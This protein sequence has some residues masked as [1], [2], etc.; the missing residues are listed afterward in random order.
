MQLFYCL[1]LLTLLLPCKEIALEWREKWQ[2]QE[3]GV[4]G[5]WIKYH[6]YTPI[7]CWCN[8]SII[9]DICVC[10]E[11]PFPIQKPPTPTVVRPPPPPPT[12][13]PLP[14][15]HAVVRRALQRLDAW[16]Q[17]IW[18]NRVV[19]TTWCQ[20]CLNFPPKIPAFLLSFYGIGPGTRT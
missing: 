5:I 12:P 17:Q 8:K 11:P 9:M 19:A 4:G 10:Y 15:P 1:T 3:E 2:R 7:M 14:H 20:H 18:E 16:P 13:L 6:V